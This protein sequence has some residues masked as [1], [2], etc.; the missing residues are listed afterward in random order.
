MIAAAFIFLAVIV[1]LAVLWAARADRRERA[2]RKED[3][4]RFSRELDRW[5]KA[6]EEMER[7]GR[8]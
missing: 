7:R 2:N 8:E 5:E 3:F 4:E 1:V 6:R